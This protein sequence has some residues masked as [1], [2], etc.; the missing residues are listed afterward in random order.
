MN[1]NKTS[2]NNFDDSYLNDSSAETK[3]GKQFDDKFWSSVDV[4]Y[5]DPF[6]KTDIF[7][8]D[9]EKQKEIYSGLTNIIEK[10][11]A[12]IKKPSY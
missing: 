11:D 3:D 8:M 1:R 2:Q 7:M 12:K 5:K 9:E 4:A 10:M 6:N